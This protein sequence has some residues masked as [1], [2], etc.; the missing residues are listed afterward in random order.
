MTI[1]PVAVYAAVVATGTG[2][3]VLGNPLNLGSSGAGGTIFR[4]LVNGTFTPGTVTVTFTAGAFSDETSNYANL[5][6]I[7]TFTVT[8]PT[9]FNPAAFASLRI[10]GAWPGASDAACHA[11]T[12]ACCWR[13]SGYQD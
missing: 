11:S 13:N 7:A 12:L 3:A 4:Y 6:S 5:E 8:G 9:R 10:D 1:G 2:D